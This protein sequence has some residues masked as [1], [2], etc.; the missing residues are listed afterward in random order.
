MTDRSLFIYIIDDVSS[1][2]LDVQ[3]NYNDDIITRYFDLVF[4]DIR[5]LNDSWRVKNKQKRGSAL[6]NNLFL[7]NTLSEIATEIEKN[8]YRPQVILFSGKLA[9]WNRPFFRFIERRGIPYF[10]RR[11]KSSF[12]SNTTQNIL[13]S[14]QNMMN[15]HHKT[16]NSIYHLILN[17][18]MLQL[19]IKGPDLLF[20][21]TRHDKQHIYFPYH[22]SRIMYTHTKDYD[23][24]LRANVK[25]ESESDFILFVDQYIPFHSETRNLGIDPTLFYKNI[26]DTLTILST[27][28]KKEI[29]F[30]AHPSSDLNIL[31]TYVPERLLVIGKTHEMIIRSSFV[32]TINSSTVLSAYLAQKPVV[33]I[34][35]LNQFTESFNLATH[36]LESHF[37]THSI[38]ISD[39]LFVQKVKHELSDYR[40]NESVYNEY[41]KH[42]NTPEKLE[43]EIICETIQTYLV[44]IPGTAA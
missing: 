14:K 9:F 11:N 41:I 15:P 32:V 4:W 2:S 10:F 22:E 24:Y 33:L 39:P 34:T 38:D 13:A 18:G 6:S 19:G 36:D 12:F 31:K 17:S 16:I 20:L 23:L 7:L 37:L 21:G 8:T 27:S 40:W 3:S 44:N 26:V 28:L 43:F 30:A 42:P 29:R 25:P 5:G 1:T 35:M